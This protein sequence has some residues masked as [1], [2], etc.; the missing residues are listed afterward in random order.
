MG[1]SLLAI[2]T[3]F[4]LFISSFFDVFKEPE[5]YSPCTPP[6]NYRLGN[7]DPKFKITEKKFLEHVNEATQ[8]WKNA[9]GRDVFIHDEDGVPENS[10]RIITISMVYDE[11][12]RLN[13]QIRQ[14]KGQV[15]NENKKIEASIAEYEGRVK[16]FKERSQAL[17]EKI[18]NLSI[19]DPEYRQKFDEAFR[20]SEELNREADELNQM[21]AALNQSTDSYNK[22][23]GRLNNT[24]SQFNQSITEKPEEG[25]YM[26][27]GDI[28][29]IYLTISNDELVHTLAHEFGHALGIEHI[30]NKESVMYPFTTE[31]IEAIPEDVTA[32]HEACKE[33][34]KE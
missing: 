32:I 11:R 25:I 3:A 7:I 31:V 18:K 29:E 13:T 8:I 27:E 9:L 5:I 23:V 21:A 22:E 2:I 28:I 16:V 1:L 4:F 20:E 19:D 10:E 34:V 24:I 26:S 17:S 33:R 12:Q 15:G 14:L 6:I 30:D